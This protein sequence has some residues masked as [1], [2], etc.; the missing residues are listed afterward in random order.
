[1]GY[2]DGEL[3]GIMGYLWATLRWGVVR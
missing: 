1:M 3:W 2:L